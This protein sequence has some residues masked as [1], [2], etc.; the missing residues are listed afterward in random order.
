MSERVTFCRSLQ[1]L[2]TRG[3]T[4]ASRVG[5][6]EVADAVRQGLE[7]PSFFSS[8]LTAPWNQDEPPPTLNVSPAPSTDEK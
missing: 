5:A 1:E 6:G 7:K 8:L 4:C 3:I 2:G